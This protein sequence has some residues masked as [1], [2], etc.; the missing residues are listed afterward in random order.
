MRLS[1]C[2]HLCIMPALADERRD[3]G[4][5]LLGSYMSGNNAAGARCRET[6]PVVMSYPPEVREGFGRVQVASR[7]QVHLCRWVS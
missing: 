7:W 5:L 2:L 6:Q 1:P 4:F 3:E